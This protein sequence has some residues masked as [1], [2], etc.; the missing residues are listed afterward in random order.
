MYVL[1]PAL[2]WAKELP[3][4]EVS[5]TIAGLLGN[6]FLNIINNDY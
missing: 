1:R 3:Y 4:T 6:I 2:K 5:V